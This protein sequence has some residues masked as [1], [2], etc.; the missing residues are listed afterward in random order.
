MKLT[1]IFYFKINFLSGPEKGTKFII[2]NDGL[3]LV[4]NRKRISLSWNDFHGLLS[5]DDSMVD[6]LNYAHQRFHSMERER[7]GSQ[8]NCDRSE[9]C[10]L[11]N[12]LN[13]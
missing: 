10:Q 9:F 2:S 4:E 12:K 13:V 7:R 5:T 1:V 3:I 6:L 11:M 8:G